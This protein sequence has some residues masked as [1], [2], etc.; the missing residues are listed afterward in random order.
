MAEQE[1]LK[2]FSERNTWNLKD[3]NENFLDLFLDNQGELEGN[4]MAYKQTSPYE[5][6]LPS[7]FKKI[8]LKKKEKKLHVIII[9]HHKER[10]GA[11]FDLEYLDIFINEKGITFQDMKSKCYRKKITILFA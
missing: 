5:F 1:F 4:E 3:D 10:I 2:L 9:W 7:T 6:Q 8:V 11:K